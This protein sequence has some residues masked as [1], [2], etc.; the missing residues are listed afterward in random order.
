L[1]NEFLWEIVDSQ[2]SPYRKQGMLVLTAVPAANITMAGIL[3]HKS[4][5]NGG[6][7]QQMPEFAIF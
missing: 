4:T 5:V 1:A 6:A 2:G 7:W 3:G